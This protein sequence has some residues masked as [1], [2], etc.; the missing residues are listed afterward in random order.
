MR[1]KGKYE[2]FECTKNAPMQLDCIGALNS[3]GSSEEM[4]G[5]NAQP[6]DRE[7]AAV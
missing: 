1:M 7:D 5:V 6:I 2:C 3:L 4:E